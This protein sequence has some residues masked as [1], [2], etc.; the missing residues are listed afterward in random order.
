[1]SIIVETP[2][3]NF[4]G[5]D[6][7]P[8]TNG[9][10]Y[11]GQVGTDPTVFA[12]QIPVFWDEALTIPAAQ[13]LTTSAGYIV[14]TGTPSRVYVAT[15]YSISVKNASNVLVYY[16][17]Q[18]GVT[19]QASQAELDNLSNSLQIPDYATLRASTTPRK[20]V[21][22]TGIYGAT[23]AGIS[24]WFLRDDADTTSLDNGGTIIVRSDGVRYKRE[25]VER[26]N[27]QWFGAVPSQSLNNSSMIQ[28]AFD[29]AKLAGVGAYIPSSTAIGYRID[30][31]L[32]LDSFFVGITG[33]SMAFSTLNYTG[34]GTALSF[35]TTSGQLGVYSNFQIQSGLA[36]ESIATRRAVSRG[37][38]FWKCYGGQG[39]ISN[40]KVLGF[41][42]FGSKFEA[43][44]D[45][46][47]EGLLVESCGG[48]GNYA[49]G[50]IN[51]TD[52]SNH[53]VFTR[54][55]VEASVGNAVYIEGLNMVVIGLH[56]E[57]TVGDGS[58]SH[59]FLG[60][61]TLID[62]RI[63][64]TSGIKVRIG[65]ATGS[66]QNFKIYGGP[67]YF[68]WGSRIVNP[69][70]II[71]CELANVIIPNTNLRQYDFVGG[72]MISMAT[73]YPEKQTTLTGVT[74][75]GGITL[76]GSGV[77]LNIYDG[78]VIGNIISSGGGV[79]TVEVHDSDLAYYPTVQVALMYNSTFDNIHS[80]PGGQKARSYDCIFRAEIVIQNNGTK[81]ET[82]GCEYGN[83]ITLGLGT[84]GWKFGKGDWVSSGAVSAG[85]LAAPT[86]SSAY[87]ANG[88]YTARILKT[89]GQPKG[90]YCT[91]AGVSPTLAFTSE[92]NL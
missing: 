62:G 14:R 58:Y 71:D 85:L 41:N 64:D 68:D 73:A 24:G 46:R 82:Q 1:M 17:A 76:T 13:P 15:D 45:S 21:Y 49:L 80:T 28:A 48:G 53:C 54:L 9:K 88:E 38:I 6:G 65:I 44:W 42:G 74:V 29:A 77:R 36:G 90:W 84:P 12:N 2:F 18:F 63:E 37:G 7:K 86:S 40:V 43:I 55:Q 79:N 32:L 83:G 8:L 50:V 87:F 57:R 39:E 5:L 16:L 69:A 31:G 26:M 22:I 89:V 23:F 59:V 67:T 56:S 47:I 3:Q 81:W 75:T 61:L 92:G 66:M 70:R 91:T 34:I 19:D 35:K 72:S 30:Q 27:I 20:S 52:T 10:V 33:D 51:G 60:D 78:T 25:R 4:T 11:I